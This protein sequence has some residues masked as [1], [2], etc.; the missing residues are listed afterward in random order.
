VGTDRMVDLTTGTLNTSRLEI[1]SLEMK[2]S[3]SSPK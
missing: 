3:T 2:M 1:F